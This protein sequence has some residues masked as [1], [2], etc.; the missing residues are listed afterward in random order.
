M[1]PGCAPDEERDAKRVELRVWDWWSPTSNDDFSDYFAAMKARFEQDHPE[2]DVQFQ[3]VPF[4]TYTQKL[5]T[6][7]AGANP[8]DVFQCSVAW[9]QTFWERGV[10]MDLTDRVAATPELAMGQFLNTAVRHN[11]LDGHIFGV[12]II[13]DA[14]C[15]IYN[16][17]MFE[18][19]GLPTEPGAIKNWDDLRRFANALTYT[20]P[21]GDKVYGFAFAGTGTGMIHFLPLMAANG[22]RFWSD[23]PYRAIFDEPQSVAVLRYLRALYYEDR[24]CP[25]FSPQLSIESEFYAG[26]VAMLVGGTWS[27]KTIDRETG[28]YLGAGHEGGLRYRMTNFPPGPSSPNGER[29]TITWGNMMVISKNA[30]HPD[31]AWEYVKL[32]AGLEGCLIRLRTLGMNAPRKDFYALTRQDLPD[33]W[34]QRGYETWG[35]VVARKPYLANVPEICESGDKLPNIERSVIDHVFKN[36]YETVMLTRNLGDDQIQQT[37]NDT[38]RRADRIYELYRPR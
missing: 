24:V 12:P 38:A 23:P 16:L 22:G 11:Q 36:A 9:A 27:G 28:S 35:D 10:L 26:R 20:K 30:R 29:A 34:V 21:N 3:F 37:M 32:A 19:A 8:P 25:T 4:P 18:A 13:L 2:V 17:D 5:T 6:A 33:E 31:L 15:L 14:E 1:L 7:Y